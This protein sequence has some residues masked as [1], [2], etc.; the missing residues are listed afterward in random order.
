MSLPLEMPVLETARLR[1]RPFVL[2][3]LQA[4]HRLLDVD[5]G[6]VPPVQP[7][8]LGERED[9]LRWTVLNYTQL[10]ALYQPPYGDRAVVLKETGALIGACGFVPCLAPFDQYPFF[11]PEGPQPGARF[12]TEL[13]LFYAISPAQQRRGYATEAARALVDYAFQSLRLKRV[14]AMTTYA[15]RASIGVME[16]LGMRIERNPF[17]DPEW[18]QVTGILE[19]PDGAL[20]GPALGDR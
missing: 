4:V 9:W 17:P 16:K 10:A 20:P 12:S 19:A 8:S 5:A 18:A 13:G 2:E 3:D 1:I 14:V 6:S 7:A 15:N 11:R